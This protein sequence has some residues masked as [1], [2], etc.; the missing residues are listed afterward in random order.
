MDGRTDRQTE[1]LKDVTKLIDS[2]LH[3]ANI[4]EISNILNK[5]FIIF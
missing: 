4:P 3:I 1:N 5:Y 2:P